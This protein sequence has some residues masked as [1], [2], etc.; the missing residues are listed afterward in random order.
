MSNICPIHI[1]GNKRKIETH[2]PVSL[3]PIS[4]KLFEKIVFN[5]VFNYLEEQNVLSKYQSGF[6][7]NDSCINQL[8]GIVNGMYQSFDGDP[9]LETRKVF[10]EVNKA[11]DKV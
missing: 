6:Q 9:A 11:F 4:D 5:S 2:K 8:L 10:L 3:L 1:K 7:P